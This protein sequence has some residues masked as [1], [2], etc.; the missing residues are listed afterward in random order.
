MR[1]LCLQILLEH[2]SCWEML[3]KYS[4]G[5]QRNKLNDEVSYVI[6]TEVTYRKIVLKVRLFAR[7]LP[8]R[9]FHLALHLSV[10]VLFDRVTPH[11]GNW[12]IIRY[13]LFNLLV[14]K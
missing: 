4:F 12:K 1:P 8:P 7:F 6:Y 3:N 2:E 5:K 11:L 13:L 9:A 14:K 10:P